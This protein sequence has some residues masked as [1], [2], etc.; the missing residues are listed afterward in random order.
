MRYCKFYDFADT[1]SWWTRLVALSKKGWQLQS[2]TL[3]DVSTGRI[4]VVMQG[5]DAE[6]TKLANRI[7]GI[8]Y[9]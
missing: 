8:D 1:D 4:M 6:V 2:I 7:T 5:K 3:V 9:S